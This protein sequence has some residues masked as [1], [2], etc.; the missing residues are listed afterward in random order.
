MAAKTHPHLDHAPSYDEQ[1]N[2]ASNRSANPWLHD[3]L[4]ASVDRRR[5]LQGTLASAAVCF[6]AP[7]APAL[8][9][10]RH[11]RN[12]HRRHRG[13]VDFEPVSIEQGTA[14]QTLPTIS[15]DYEYQVLIP[16][17]VDLH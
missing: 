5:V 4:G 15:D 6:L 7:A 8:A 2:T 10:G 3:V 11:H 17:G 16:W 14:D 13:L 9:S 1:E 12:D